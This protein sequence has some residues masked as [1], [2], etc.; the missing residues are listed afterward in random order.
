M[1]LKGNSPEANLSFNLRTSVVVFLS[2]TFALVSQACPLVGVQGPRQSDWSSGFAEP[3]GSGKTPSLANATFSSVRTATTDMPEPG[4]R[5]AI[6]HIGAVREQLTSG[7][8][9][10]QHEETLSTG[11]TASRELAQAKITG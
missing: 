8:H 11:Q 5:P 3:S 6:V 10:A 1:V 4:L 9:L 2:L 7:K